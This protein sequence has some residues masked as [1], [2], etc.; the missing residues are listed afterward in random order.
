M[1]V[2]ASQPVANN[3][4]GDSSFPTVQEG[5]PSNAF[6]TPSNDEVP[7]MKC[8]SLSSILPFGF[9]M[10]KG[11][12]PLFRLFQIIDILRDPKRIKTMIICIIVYHLLICNIRMMDVD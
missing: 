5:P 11:I 1:D 10:K 12:K 6:L 2:C 8:H 4:K 7:M 3:E 9:K